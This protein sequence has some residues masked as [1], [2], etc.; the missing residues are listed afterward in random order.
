MLIG[1]ESLVEGGKRPSIWP[2]PILLRDSSA[3]LRC[4]VTRALMHDIGTRF[5]GRGCVQAENPRPHQLGSH[6]APP[7]RREAH[8]G[9]WRLDLLRVEACARGW[10]PPRLYASRSQ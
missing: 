10:A 4:V 7:A 3:K 8:T 2:P 1:D 6:H 9:P 5:A